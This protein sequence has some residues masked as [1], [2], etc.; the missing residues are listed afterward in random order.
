MTLN[1]NMDMLTKDGKCAESTTKIIS[2]V[3]E[4]HVLKMI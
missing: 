4:M 2:V 1:V 3:W